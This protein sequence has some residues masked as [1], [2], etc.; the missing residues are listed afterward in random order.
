MKKPYLHTTE[1]KSIQSEE[2]NWILNK[3]FGFIDDDMYGVIETSNVKRYY[4]NPI[5][6]DNV[7]NILEDIKESGNN[8]VSI[9]YHRLHEEYVFKPL[10]IAKSTQEQIDVYEA[11]ELSEKE[12]NDKIKALEAQIAELKK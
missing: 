12:K 4:N 11:K 3:T 9:N 1:Q 8:F 7:I 10:H 6:L 2:T 5:L